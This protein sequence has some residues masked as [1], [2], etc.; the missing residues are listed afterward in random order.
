MRTFST[1]GF[2]SEILLDQGGST[3]EGC[4]YWDSADLKRAFIL[5]FIISKNISY[6]GRH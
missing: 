5:Q 4:R 2:R 3:C 6:M 1:S